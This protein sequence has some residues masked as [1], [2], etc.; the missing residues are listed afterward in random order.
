ME[1]HDERI[2][3]WDELTERMSSNL[4]RPP[5]MAQMNRAD[6]HRTKIELAHTFDTMKT[7]ADRFGE[8]L[9]IMTLRKSQPLDQ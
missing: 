3:R 2:E 9:W 7:E 6:I 1:N 8:R 5:F 4:D